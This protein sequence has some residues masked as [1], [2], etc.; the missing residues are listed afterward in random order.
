MKLKLLATTAAA[1]LVAS[2]GLWAQ[3]QAPGQKQD[4]KAQMHDQKGAGAAKQNRDEGTLAKERPKA[5]NGQHAQDVR[6]KG[7][8]PRDQVNAK[9]NDPSK[10]AEQVPSKPPNAAAENQKKNEPR[11]IAAPRPPR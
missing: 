8:N 3:A 1:A 6:Q 2:G 11:P 4:E 5:A 7:N 9:R 10:A